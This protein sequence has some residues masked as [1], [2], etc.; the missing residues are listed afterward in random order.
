LI[1]AKYLDYEIIDGIFERIKNFKASVKLSKV[2]GKPPI[3]L[4]ELLIQKDTIPNEDH[5]LHAL[6]NAN[7]CITKYIDTVKLPEAREGASIKKNLYDYQEQLLQEISVIRHVMANVKETSKISLKDK[8]LVS[9]NTSGI[10]LEYSLQNLSLNS[11]MFRHSFDSPL[12]FC[13]PMGWEYF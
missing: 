8:M 11:A 1:E 5:L 7:E 12:Q 10:Q 9:F 13:L 6:A 4:S 3:R 2:L